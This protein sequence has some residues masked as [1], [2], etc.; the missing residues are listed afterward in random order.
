MKIL[1]ISLLFVLLATNTALGIDWVMGDKKIVIV[2]QTEPLS[3]AETAIFNKISSESLPAISYL[4]IARHAGGTFL[5]IYKEKLK[6]KEAQIPDDLGFL[7][8]IGAS[9]NAEGQT[10]Q[11]EE[12]VNNLMKSVQEPKKG[13]S[14]KK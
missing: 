9:F 11:F 5:E 10:R 8:G 7:I 6:G 14:N 4:Y 12:A 13:C 2:N 1:L 3:D